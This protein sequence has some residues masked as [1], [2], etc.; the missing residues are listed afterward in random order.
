[1]IITNTYFVLDH[2]M[3]SDSELHC[4]NSIISDR[5]SAGSIALEPDQGSDISYPPGMEITRDDQDTVCFRYKG[6][7]LNLNPNKTASCYIDAPFEMLMQ[8]VFPIIHQ[9][10]YF[11]FYLDNLVDRIL[12]HSF[13]LYNDRTLG[14]RYEASESFRSFIWNDFP[15]FKPAIMADVDEF[16]RILL[17]KASMK[18]RHIFTVYFTRK[19]VCDKDGDLEVVRDKDNEPVRN[20]N[21]YDFRT[22]GLSAASST[23]VNETIDTVLERSK[24]VRCPTCNGR[25]VRKSMAVYHPPFTFFYDCSNSVEHPQNIPF[26]PQITIHGVPYV[27]HGKII[28]TFKEGMHY[29]NHC[30]I[31]Q[32]DGQMFLGRIDNLD[33]AVAVI[34]EADANIPATLARN[35]DCTVIV[36]Y[37]RQHISPTASDKLYCH[38]LRA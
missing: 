35:P 21:P 10:G 5:P 17:E 16:F 2:N 27:L 29:F 32:P 3:L 24:T 22:R 20:M 30:S 4:N 6:Y 18:L 31:L 8:S 15:A 11:P 19:T 12:H 23:L 33:N 26:P 1:M 28:S 38:I 7:L 36:C 13:R 9:E 14:S 37:R 34:Q 25:A